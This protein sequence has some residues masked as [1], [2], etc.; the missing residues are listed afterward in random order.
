MEPSIDSL[1]LDFQN[2]DAR[3]TEMEEK[4]DKNDLSTLT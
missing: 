1:E 4:I 3:L 2:M